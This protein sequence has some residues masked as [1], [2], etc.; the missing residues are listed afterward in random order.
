MLRAQV[1]IVRSPKLY[2]TV[3][4]IIKLLGGRPVHEKATYR[5]YDTRGC[6]VQF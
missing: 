6:I 1:L 2:Y 5:F 3:S 4:G